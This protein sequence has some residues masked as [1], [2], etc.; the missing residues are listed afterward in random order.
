MNELEKTFYPYLIESVK[1]C[2]CFPEDIIPSAIIGPYKV[3]FLFGG[4]IFE[5]DGYEFHKSKE[6]RDRDYKRERYF[7]KT[8]YTVIRFTGTEIFLDP[9]KCAKEAFEIM[10]RA[11]K[12]YIEAFQLGRKSKR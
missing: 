8:G 1:E 10:V 12:D 6:Q 9:N 2:G 3:D 5:L 4:F 11:E 7:Q